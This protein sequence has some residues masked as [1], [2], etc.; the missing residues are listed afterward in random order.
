MVAPA[1]EFPAEHGPMTPST[2]VECTQG[3][4]DTAPCRV[5]RTMDVRFLEVMTCSES[6]W[7]VTSLQS[8][9]TVM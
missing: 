8:Q 4:C 2:P 1:S 3:N 5:M 6:D 7:L 9:M